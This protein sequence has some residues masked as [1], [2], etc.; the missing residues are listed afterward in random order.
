MN[1]CSKPRNLM[2]DSVHTRVEAQAALVRADGRVELHTVAAVHLHPARCHPP[3]PRGTCRN[4][5]GSHMRSTMPHCSSSGRFSSIGLKAFQH[6]AHCLQRFRL[7]GVARL[8]GGV[9]TGQIFVFQHMTFPFPCLRAPPCAAARPSCYQIISLYQGEGKKILHELTRQRP[10][11]YTKN[12]EAS[13]TDG[14]GGP[15]RPSEESPG[16]SRER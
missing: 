4:R 2:T 16:S 5:S 7:A 15:E 8:H 13:K 11:W 1:T 3:R 14:G 9:Y 10:V 12:S 6:L